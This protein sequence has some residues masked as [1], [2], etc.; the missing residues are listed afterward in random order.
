MLLEYVGRKP[1]VDFMESLHKSVGFSGKRIDDSDN[2]EVKEEQQPIQE[3][4]QVD[5]S[6]LFIPFQL[7][8]CPFPAM[9]VHKPFDGFVSLYRFYLLRLLLQHPCLL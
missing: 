7:S 8:T 4:L 1:E 5:L 3:P 6:G 2:K 9:S